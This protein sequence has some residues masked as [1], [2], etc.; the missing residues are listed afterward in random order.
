MSVGEFADEYLK[1]KSVSAM[2]TT[3][4]SGNA[5]V[6]KAITVGVLVQHPIVCSWFHAVMSNNHQPV[7]E[8]KFFLAARCCQVLSNQFLG[9]R[10][11]DISSHC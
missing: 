2:Q 3:A 7:R 9:M 4:S 10:D 1:N 6:T 8:Y 5:L 11:W